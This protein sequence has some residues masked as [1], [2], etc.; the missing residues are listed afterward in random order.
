MSNIQN[1]SSVMFVSACEQKI[2][3]VNTWGSEEGDQQKFEFWGNLAFAESKKLEFF[4]FLSIPHTPCTKTALS[5][6]W[7][8]TLF[9]FSRP[10]THNTRHREDRIKTEYGLLV[11]LCSPALSCYTYVHRG[12]LQVYLPPQGTAAFFR[13][14]GLLFCRNLFHYLSG[15]DLGQKPWSQVT[16]LCEGY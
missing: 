3:S 13:N 11:Q 7:H 1:Y 6:P 4:V 8:L 2:L 14:W 9:T 12:M 15:S 5:L 10:G 16:M